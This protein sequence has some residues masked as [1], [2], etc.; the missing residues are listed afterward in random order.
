MSFYLPEKY[1]E[2]PPK[3]KEEG[4]YTESR[5]EMEV[6][7][8]TFGGRAHGKDWTREIDNLKEDLKKVCLLL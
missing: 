6:Y 1:Q 5:E 2:N 8:R 4:V 7:V 3:P